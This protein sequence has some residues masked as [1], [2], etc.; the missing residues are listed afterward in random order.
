MKLVPEVKEFVDE[1]GTT[2]TFGYKLS[3]FEATRPFEPQELANPE[4]QTLTDF[5]YALYASAVILALIVFIFG[6]RNV[7]K[8]NIEWRR[9]FV[10][11][12]AFNLGIYGWRMLYYISNFSEVLS[13]TGYFVVSINTL[14]LS[15]VLSL[16][17]VLAYI[18]WEVFARAQKNGEIQLVDNIWRMNIWLKESG[19]AMLH[20][21]SLGFLLLGVFVTTSSAMVLA[22]WRIV[23][24]SATNFAVGTS[25]TTCGAAMPWIEVLVTPALNNRSANSSAIRPNCVTPMGPEI[26]TSVT[27]SLQLPRKI[28]GSS[29]SS[30]NVE[31]PASAVSTS[32]FARDISQS[33][34]N[35]NL[36]RASPSVDR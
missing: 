31:M 25:I 3:S 19:Q 29:A 15:L 11:F 30:G 17:G 23:M 7:I 18:N 4:Q 12:I 9:A 28:T 14:L 8:G 22:I 33:G 21:F 32:E 36:L 34:S 35:S 1:S 24:S 26:T 6:V 5:D 13:T 16:F 10:V 2:T 20:G 27:R